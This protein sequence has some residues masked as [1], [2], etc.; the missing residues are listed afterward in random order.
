[1]GI[2]GA[3][4]LEQ[5][6]VAE[7]SRQQVATSGASVKGSHDS[8]Q[9]WQSALGRRWAWAAAQPS[10]RVPLSGRA[11]PSPWEWA[12]LWALPSLWG[13]VSVLA[14]RRVE[15]SALPATVSRWPR[16]LVNAHVECGGMSS[17]A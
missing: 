14:L 10:A 3:S 15:W 1:M 9:L 8:K 11:L 12:S 2:P 6:S 13:L 17:G 5:G 4:V 7:T 16:Q